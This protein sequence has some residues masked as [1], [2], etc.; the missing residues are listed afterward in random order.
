MRDHAREG[1]AV[2][3]AA[4][5]GSAPGILWPAEYLGSRLDLSPELR[6]AWAGAVRPRA[7]GSGPE[8]RRES[9]LSATAT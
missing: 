8:H 3:G 7:A 1:P 9:A 6:D 5:A 2:R 4:P